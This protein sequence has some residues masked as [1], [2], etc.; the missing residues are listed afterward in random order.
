MPRYIAHITFNATSQEEAEETAH[1]MARAHNEWNH[2]SYHGP[3]TLRL[4]LDN[5]LLE[6]EV[7]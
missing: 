6:A 4:T 3:A 7:E 5:T 2:E 1:R